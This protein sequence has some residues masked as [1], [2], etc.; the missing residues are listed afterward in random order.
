LLKHINILLIFI[1]SHFLGFAQQPSHFIIG[2]EELSGVDIYDIKQDEQKIYWLGTNQGIIK[3]DGYTFKTIKC[4]EMLSTSVFDLQFNSKKTLYCKN[5]SGQIFEI[6]NDTCK[7]FFTIPDSLM[8]HEFYY[9]F[10][11]NDKLIIASN[12]IFE[13]SHKTD[14]K[15]I[16]NINLDNSYGEFFTTKTGSLLIHNYIT[17]NLIELKDNK[18]TLTPTPK[19]NDFV[20]QYFYLKDKLFIYDKRSGQLLN[21][22]DF[23]LNK[24]FIPNNNRKELLRYYTDNENL[25]IAKQSGGIKIFDKNLSPLYNGNTVF[26]NTIIT[27]FCKDVEGNILLGTFGEGL[28]VISNFNSDEIMLPDVRAK[29]SRITAAND[30]TIFLGTQDGRIYKVDSTNNVSLFQNK[31]NKNI[32]VLE[33]F[34]ETN[35]LLIDDK[36]PLLININDGKEKSYAI[37]AIKDVYKISTGKYIIASN[38][39][40]AIIHL[41]NNDLINKSLGAYEG[42]TNCV[43]YDSINN[44]IYAGSSKG[45][46]IGS[47]ENFEYFQLENQAILCK[48]ILYLN[49]KIYITTHT[50]GVLIFKNKKLINAWNISTGLISNNTKHI[51]TYQNKIYLTT[52]LGLQIL[53][54]D[55]IVLFTLS[56][57]EGLYTNNIIDFEIQNGNLWL[58][59]QKGVQTIKISELK[60]QTFKPSIK[61]MQIV[62]NDSI[63]SENNKNEFN[64]TQNKIL[65]TVSSSSIRYNNDI[66]YKYLLEGV[67]NGWQIANYENNHIEYKLL[68]SG[69]YTFKIKATYGDLESKMITY[70]FKINP[71]IWKTWWFYLVIVIL[72]ILLTFFIFSSQL[73]KQKKKIK[74]QNELNAAKLIAIQSQMNPHFIF[75][76]INSIQDL[77][78]KGD[79]DNSYNYIIKLSKLVRQ[80]LN[81][82]DKD[83]IDIEDEVELLEIYLALEKLRFKDDFIYEIAINNLNDIQ[84]PPMLIQP[85]VENAIKHGLLHQDGQKKLNI[86]LTYINEQV[87]HCKII[88]NGVGRKKAQEIKDR[89]QKNHQSF[90]VNATKTR[91][92]IM[93]AHYQ[94]N[95][96]ITYIDLYKNEISVGTEVNIV[97]PIN[98]RY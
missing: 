51:K 67:D 38:R 70:S 5:L 55:G 58:V 98:Q 14:I 75:N 64:Y 44:T 66:K 17:N 94:Q 95:L 63:L 7:I 65:F 12:S 9:S 22:H 91:F 96:G 29:V 2:E 35:Q 30:K 97:L 80:T 62:V 28:I 11:K 21:N 69:N 89:Q 42:R 33:C 81:F 78:L 87:I 71:P 54:L 79:I 41:V 82:S 90:S 74:L 40:I 10:T 47:S 1:L 88:D 6:K 31:H 61:F 8:K 46:K 77:I 83:F 43:G 25:W 50:N 93:K 4:P 92:D 84:I 37:G 13:V 59:H 85:F 48:D 56:K 53:S 45:L 52:N 15:L 18:I 16:E 68:S 73:K 34:K 60:T 49:G 24:T 20:I 36:S 32:E 26:E 86:S 76:T 72:F 27:T 39:G 57:S 3:F 19:N 23:Y